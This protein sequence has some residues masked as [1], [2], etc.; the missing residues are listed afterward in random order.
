MENHLSDIIENLHRVLLGKALDDH[1]LTTVTI[2]KTNSEFEALM[3]SNSTLE[4]QNK[5]LKAKLESE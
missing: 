3:L 5:T 2:S 1:S 4:E